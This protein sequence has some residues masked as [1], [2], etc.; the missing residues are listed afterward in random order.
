MPDVHV[1]RVEFRTALVVTLAVASVLL[2]LWFLWL[3]RYVII[4][5]VL[6][7][8]VASA[9]EP[10]VV[11]LRRLGTRRG[12]AVLLIL[13][14]LGLVVLGIVFAI[15]QTLQAEVLAIGNNLPQFVDQWRPLVAQIPIRP[16][17]QGLGGYLDRLAQPAAPDPAVVE[18][19]LSLAVGVVETILSGFFVLV[20][21]YYWIEERVLIRRT[22]VSVLPDE[23]EERARLIWEDVELKLGGW[24]RGQLLIM[25]CVGT[26]ATLAFWLLGLKYAIVLGVLA[27]LAEMLPMIGPYL[28]ALPALLIALTQDP[29]LA[30]W[31]GV[32]AFGIHLVEGYVLVP[33][34]MRH[35][36]GLSSLTIVLGLVVGA[37]AYGVAGAL[38]A[39]PIAGIVQVLFTDLVRRST[40]DIAG[41]VEHVHVEHMGGD[42]A[43]SKERDTAGAP[44]LPV[45]H[46]SR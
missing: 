41:E 36:V 14:G 21:A 11:R 42:P 33:W 26:L 38:L 29:W 45:V 24:V 12:H 7:L 13:G 39:I 15:V 23:H 27:G 34:I 8:L 22:L 4:L 30:V 18:N 5:F 40:P 2:G 35:T 43:S 44:A 17:A 6:A 31:V 37:T 32:A 3:I 1:V 46:T 16:V 9:I 25:L 10:L 19:A 20:I 28:G